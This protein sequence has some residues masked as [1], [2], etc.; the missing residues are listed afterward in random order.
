MALDIRVHFH[1]HF[2][3]NLALGSAKIFSGY[4]KVVAEVRKLHLGIIDY[5]E[6]ANA[7]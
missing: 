6:L 5:G 3:Y 2:A 1:H 7:W 4:E